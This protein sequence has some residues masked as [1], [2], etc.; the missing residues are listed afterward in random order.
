MY[1]MHACMC[2]MLV[3]LHAPKPA[4]G[5]K[6]FSLIHREKCSTKPE[7]TGNKRIQN[8][9]NVISNPSFLSYHITVFTVI[10]PVYN[11]TK[12]GEAFFSPDSP[13]N[14]IYYLFII[15]LYLNSSY[16]FWSEM[17]S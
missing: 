1:E 9:V 5:T 3:N 8:G 16:S 12:I 2:N 13:T 4:V 10:V 15:G 17:E 14:T 6:V 11:P 7:V